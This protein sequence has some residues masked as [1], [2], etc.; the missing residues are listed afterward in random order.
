M[1]RTLKVI[2]TSWI[3]L[4]AF[5]ALLVA[6]N[7]VA[8]RILGDSEYI[9][10]PFFIA[11]FL[12]VMVLIGAG[13]IWFI[14]FL[15]GEIDLWS[16]RLDVGHRTSGDLKNE[17][18]RPVFSR[19]G[20]RGCVAL[21]AAIVCG[22]FLLIDGLMLVTWCFE[23]ANSSAVRTDAPNE[24]PTVAPKKG[25]H[26]SGQVVSAE[27]G[28]KILVRGDDGR[29]YQVRLSEVWMPEADEAYA[30]EALSELGNKVVGHRVA[31]VG[32]LGGSP[33]R[34]GRLRVRG[35]ARQA[36]GSG[37][38]V[39]QLVSEGWALPFNFP[40]GPTNLANWERLRDAEHAARTG[41]RGL[42]AHGDAGTAMDNTQRHIQQTLKRLQKN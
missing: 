10:F 28:A 5:A 30:D 18:A 14:R 8:S 21:L 42:W 4:S 33:D 36:G 16:G 37:D 13:G 25:I 3:F 6:G 17:S 31:V 12:V 24:E 22:T 29:E 39:E 9:E 38:F 19:L 1:W 20:W 23:P 7:F 11:G 40:G 27:H 15:E 2:F 41:K 34:N 26:F 35:I 32:D